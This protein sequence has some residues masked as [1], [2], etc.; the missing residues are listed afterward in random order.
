MTMHHYH[1][2]PDGFTEAQFENLTDHDREDLGIVG[3][4]RE[5]ANQK[6][7]DDEARAN[8]KPAKKTSQ[9]NKTKKSGPARDSKGHFLKKEQ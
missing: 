3:M 2:T 4:N 9:P 5:Q 7:A 8:S 1:T 6:L